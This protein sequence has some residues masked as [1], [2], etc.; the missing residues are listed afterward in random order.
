MTHVLIFVFICLLTCVWLSKTTRHSL[1]E[2]IA[3]TAAF[4]SVLLVIFVGI[5]AST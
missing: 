1:G 5:W 3:A 2:T 4:S